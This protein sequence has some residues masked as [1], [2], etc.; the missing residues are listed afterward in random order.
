MRGGGSTHHAIPSPLACLFCVR[1]RVRVRAGLAVC[2]VATW[3]FSQKGVLPAN[4]PG[5]IL[6]GNVTDVGGMLWRK[7]VTRQIDA[8]LS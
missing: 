1:T 8:G 6:A 7:E 5:F 2:I 3:T 4:K